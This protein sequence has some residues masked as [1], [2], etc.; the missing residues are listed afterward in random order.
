MAENVAMRLQE[1]FEGGDFTPA[2]VEAFRKELYREK[3]G[4]EALEVVV[5]DLAAQSS[6][7]KGVRRLALGV[8]QWMNGQVN[9]AAQT[10]ASTPSS[11]L[12]KFY[13]GLL[14]LEKGHYRKALDLFQAVGELKGSEFELDRARAR[15]LR[16]LGDFEGA[17]KLL[18]R[19][20]KTHS[21]RPDYHYEVGLCLDLAGARD[22]AIVS[23]E[24][25]LEYDPDHTPSLFRLAYIADLSGDDDAAIE[26]YR[27]CLERR[28]FYENALI[29]LGLLYEDRGDYNEAIRCYR[30]VLKVNPNNPRAR[31]FL[32]D[33]EA[34]TRMY[35]DEDVERRVERKNRVLD[36]PV[37]DFELSVRSRNCL[38]KMGIRT[39]GD[40]TRTTEQQLLSYK[41]FG[42]TSLAEIKGILAQKGLRLGQALE[43]G[44]AEK[45]KASAEEA[46][47][48]AALKKEIS[49]FE[50]PVR[51]RA[52]LDRLGIKTLGDLVQ[53][54][55][56]ELLACRNFGRASMAEIRRIIKSV[57]LSMKP[58]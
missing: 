11:P 2:R 44:T 10:L 54:T 25:A 39:L 53:H 48:A 40:L 42:E 18:K 8:A 35:I 30:T 47:R 5:K 28:P 57:G 37:T 46:A 55:E 29:N 31:L 26:Y 6:S 32:R 7:A 45:E 22:A 58:S 13:S 50:L 51:C 3:G 16:G 17:L 23:Y 34:S 38:E 9:E 21:H 52:C 49:D 36:T 20:S 4:S 19:H 41:N 56:G 15:A 43:E 24:K 27:K 1:F 33:A 12:Q 14:Y